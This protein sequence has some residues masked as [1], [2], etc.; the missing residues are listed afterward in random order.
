MSD[1]IDDYANR[2]TQ[3]LRQRGIVDPRIV[4]EAREHLLDT[5]AEGRRNGLSLEEAEREAFD[6][7]GAPE[8][9]A[10]HAVSE[11]VGRGSRSSPGGGQPMS[12]L[13]ATLDTVWQ[14]KWWIVV[15]AA[16]AA[17]ITTVAATYLLPTRYQSEAVI[18]LSRPRVADDSAVVARA[19]IPLGDVA[20]G[21]AQRRF[22][23][24]SRLVLSRPRLERVISD[25]G[26]YDAVS[27]STPPDDV[28]TQMR[29]D[30][31]LT[32]LD[33]D[34]R[35]SGDLGGFRV[36]FA[37]SSPQTAMRVTE[38]I[39]SLFIEEN[40]RDQDAI[41]QDVTLV[42]ESR[43]EDTRRRIVE[44]E[45]KLEELRAQQGKRPLSRADL[46]PYEV[47]QES[48]KALLTKAED[49]RTASSLER[50]Q[51][52]EQFR[53]LEAP[54][55]PDEPV[56]PSR[57]S[58]SVWGAFAGVGVGLLLVAFRGRSTEATA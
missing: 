3:A 21:A 44:Y 32:M 33:D 24:V 22:Q 47:L 30:I 38:R 29:D 45:T 15:P 56:G 39:A 19:Q 53:I 49:A 6:R 18:I 35:S 51:I 16:V 48:Y 14:R 37:A 27:N 41:A 10:A 25:F 58:V 23:E 13:A 28:V 8:I 43:I 4:A 57:V 52:G 12:R 9:V 40:L 50:R 7:F 46:L 42:V 5:V 26:L 54:R 20:D 17:M 2:L 1:P 31:A 36:S 55:L 34:Q 11:G